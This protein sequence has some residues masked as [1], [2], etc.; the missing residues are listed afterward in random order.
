MENFLSQPLPPQLLSRQSPALKSSSSD[1]G[2]EGSKDLH[3]EMQ[4]TPVD[5]VLHADCT[6]ILK[7]GEI[8]HFKQISG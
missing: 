6:T 1:M 4:H 7:Q 2:S 8:S 3:L 5:G